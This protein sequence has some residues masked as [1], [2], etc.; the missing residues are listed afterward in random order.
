MKFELRAKI[1]ENLNKLKTELESN[2]CHSILDEEDGLKIISDIERVLELDQLQ[3]GAIDK[4]S[5]SIL[6]LANQMPKEIV[7]IIDDFP[8][9]SMDNPETELYVGK[10]GLGWYATNEK[11]ILWKQ[12]INKGESFPS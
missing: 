1:R 8:N 2:C 10:N 4:N 6:F 7:R 9:K 5:Y 3:A 11:Q 12:W